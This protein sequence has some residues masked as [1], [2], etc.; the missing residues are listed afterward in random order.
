MK[1]MKK[2]PASKVLGLV[3]SIVLVSLAL[4]F[5]LQFLMP[6][7]DV[8]DRSE[9]LGLF[10]LVATAFSTITVVSLTLLHH[11]NVATT[12]AI[13]DGYGDAIS[14]RD[15]ALNHHTILSVSHADG[16]IKEVNENFVK[17]FGYRPDEIIGQTTS[18]LYFKD[19]TEVAFADVLAVAS[20]GD[21][22]KGEQRLKAKDGRTI[23]V[24]TTIIPR[25]DE[26]GVHQESISI[27]TDLTAAHNDAAAEGRNA[28]IERL[29]DGVIVYD[30]E[31]MKIN[32]VNANGRAWLGWTVDNMCEK[33]MFDTFREFDE[34]MF[35]RYLAPLLS[36]EVKQVTI[37]VVHDV[38]PI[39]ILTHIDAGPDGH[40]S[41][42]SVVRDVSERVAADKMKLTSVST[43]SH[44][45]RTP[46]T[47]IK[48][49]LRLLEAGNLGNMSSQAERMISIAHRNSDRLLALVNDILELEKIESG[50]LNVSLQNVDLQELLLEASEA[51]ASYADDAGVRFCVEPSGHPT[52]VRADPDRLMQV[53]ANLM[54]NAAKFSPAG[55]AVKLYVEDIDDDIWRICI[56]DQGPG[57]PESARKTLFDSFFQVT[58]DE[59]YARPGTGLGLTISKRLMD[60]HG[61]SISFTTEL[62]QGS[63]FHCD[64][65]K[66]AEFGAEAIY[67]A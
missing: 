55:S 59:H 8:V 40:P 22:W 17:V 48:G 42:I 25:F 2:L 50:E 13:L 4:A 12:S 41:L 62:G 54:S 34:G 56:E 44:E 31:T 5:S 6:S 67:A 53:L 21:V 18:L 63:I 11:K 28:V 15:R 23:I 20:S 27:R 51:H 49:A 46:L 47:S 1:M 24:E 37:Q 65:K 64:L 32:Y 7:L 33:T 66:H 38:G 35:R 39:E 60:L 14:M 9:F 30:P 43:V 29:P 3:L 45:L 19:G 61:G 36:G 26:A 58:A 57:I 16:R 10:L 52:M